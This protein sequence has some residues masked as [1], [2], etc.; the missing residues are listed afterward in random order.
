[1]MNVTTLGDRGQQPLEIARALSTFLSAAR[2]SLDIA[3]YDLNLG[4]ETERLVI[5]AIEDAGRR[6]VAVRLAYNADF[7]APIPVPPPP[8]CAPEDIE[9][10]RVPTK[11]IAGIPDLMHHKYAV[12]DH[13][14]VWTGSANWTDDSWS[15]EE[16]VV[17]EVDSPQLARAFTLDFEP[18]WASGNVAESGKVEPRPVE[19]DGVQVRPWFCPGF[20][21]ALS[22]RI[23]KHIG[24]AK[25]RV[26][27]C[28]PVI[29]AAP[30]LATLAQV[31]AD[32]KVDVAGAI[33]QTQIEQ[34]RD[35]W[36][37]TGVSSWKLPL[38]RQVVGSGRFSGK[39]STPWAP[40]TVHD[41]MHAK[42]TVADDV[43]FVG[44]FNLSHSGEQNAENVLEI[45]DPALA[46]QLARFVDSVHGR[47]P[48]ASLEPADEVR[49]TSGWQSD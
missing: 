14:S 7:R 5:D 3:L 11:P 27:I 45:H 47:Y 46:A 37:P 4:P 43:T 28:S 48:P 38:L 49:R 25:R 21:D 9:R 13:A 32:G 31:I 16:N 34:V 8:E 24:R 2:E 1:M 44:S 19:I 40:D 29:T 6:G 26:R 39:R 22:H 20:G 42:V 30:V 33:D 10:L 23:A 17:V 41:Y 36:G 35:Q 12:R 18:L 15:R